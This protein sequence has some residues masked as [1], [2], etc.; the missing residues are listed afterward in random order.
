M[1]FHILSMSLRVLAVILLGCCLVS[2]VSALSGPCPAFGPIHR[3]SLDVKSEY[4]GMSASDIIAYAAAHPDGM[5]SESAYVKAP[6]LIMPTSKAGTFASLSGIG[7]TIGD[8]PTIPRTFSGALLPDIMT[9][10]DFGGSA[11]TEFVW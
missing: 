3:G 7:S 5:S 4:W 8:S 10:P 11:K 2:A 6:S 1:N 9:K